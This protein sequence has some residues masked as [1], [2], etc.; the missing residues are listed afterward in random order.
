MYSII[1]TGKTF[2]G[3]NYAFS[4]PEESDA[5]QTDASVIVPRSVLPSKDFIKNEDELTIFVTARAYPKE[6]TVR[7]RRRAGGFVVHIP[8]WTVNDWRLAC[9]EIWQDR[10]FRLLSNGETVLMGFPSTR[11]SSPRCHLFASCEALRVAKEWIRVQQ[12]QQRQPIDSNGHSSSRLYQL[13]LV[14]ESNYVVD[15]IS[16][17]TR[18]MEWGSFETLKSFVFVDGHVSRCRANLDILYPLARV[19]HNLQMQF[20]KNNTRLLTLSSGTTEASIKTSK[21]VMKVEHSRSQWDQDTVQRMNRLALEA[22]MFTYN[23]R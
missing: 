7:G 1:R 19:Y 16:N 15:L 18:L 17:T 12:Q 6:E 3:H 8:T 21:F 23:N 2:R 10:R 9:S 20:Q 14:T 5:K 4:P 13:N 22:A 11:P